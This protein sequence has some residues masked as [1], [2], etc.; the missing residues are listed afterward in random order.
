MGGNVTVN[1]VLT[2][3]ASTTLDL[4]ATTL[5][6][7][8]S[9]TPLVETGTLTPSTSTVNYTNAAATNIGIASYYNLNGTGGNRTLPAGSVGIANVFTPGAGSYTV[10]SNTMDFNG[11]GAQSVPAFSYNNLT[12]SN[13]GT[14]TTGGNVTIGGN[15]LVDDGTTVS[16][17]AVD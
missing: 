6:L 1:G 11:G 17:G 7:A 4:L 3:G 13:A 8:G 12:T 16:V 15:L 10:T 2:I 5:T 9:G 14:K